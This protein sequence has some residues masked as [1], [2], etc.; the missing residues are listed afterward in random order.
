MPER[1]TYGHI[2]HIPNFNGDLLRSGETF[3]DKRGTSVHQ[4]VLKCIG[5]SE[6]QWRAKGK[7]WEWWRVI[8]THP[9]KLYTEVSPSACWC[10]VRLLQAESMAL[11]FF[12]ALGAKQKF[13]RYDETAPT[14]MQILAELYADI[15][16]WF[17]CC[18][19][20]AEIVSLC[21]NLAKAKQNLNQLWPRNPGRS[22]SFRRGCLQPV[23]YGGERSKSACNWLFWRW[24][25][26]NI[27]KGMQKLQNMI[28]R[29]QLC[30]KFIKTQGLFC[31]CKSWIKEKPCAK[32]HQKDGGWTKKKSFESF[33]VSQ[34]APRRPS[35]LR[36]PWPG[37]TL[38]PLSGDCTSEI[39]NV[40]HGNF[41]HFE[42]HW[43]SLSI[44]E[45]LKSSHSFLPTSLQTTAEVASQV[46]FQLRA[47]TFWFWKVP[48]L[49]NPYF[50]LFWSQLSAAYSSSL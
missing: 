18:S 44:I 49:E 11:T 43:T 40:R 20:L 15:L 1:A 27:E 22:S 39:R 9:Y 45:Q 23:K 31:G 24:K 37:H 7:R 13:Q 3:Q 46:C 25:I 33:E 12:A 36:W 50:E 30:S 32:R 38:R 42:H 14:P 29:V 8:Q 4:C 26:E 41:Q 28:A 19:T 5:V 2:G 35:A 16:V 47:L 6:I 10:K 21:F 34:D 17:P 48:I